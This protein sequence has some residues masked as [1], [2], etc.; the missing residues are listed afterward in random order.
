MRLR[1]DGTLVV[2]SSG[3]GYRSVTRLAAAASDIVGTHVHV[4]TDDVP[5]AAD[6]R[7]L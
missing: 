6:A 3:P 2:H 7:E 5:A 4:I 1:S